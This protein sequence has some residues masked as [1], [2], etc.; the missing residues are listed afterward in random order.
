VLLLLLL[1]VQHEM[2]RQQLP[3]VLA[4]RVVKFFELKHRDK[5]MQDSAAIMSELA[6]G[7][8]LQVG[9]T[10]CQLKAFQGL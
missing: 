3:E 4:Q 6:P 8:Q 7:L 1:Q 2:E 10:A 5:N 9:R